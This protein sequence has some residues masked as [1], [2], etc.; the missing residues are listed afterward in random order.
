MSKEED[1]LNG[2]KWVTNNV[3][4]VAIL[5]NNAGLLQE[6]NLVD[7][8]TA[9]WKRTF[10]IN[11]LGLCIAT[12]EAV[13]IMRE[14]KIDGHIIHINSVVGHTVP[15]FPGSNVYP[16]SKHSVTALTETLRQEF[17]HI[18]VKIKISVWFYHQTYMIL[19]N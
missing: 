13:K 12:R 15:N 4:P 1:I 3:G 10:D 2:F 7:G 17:N 14:N 11:V 19:I 8:D 9:K 16:A 5:V 6:T 18:G